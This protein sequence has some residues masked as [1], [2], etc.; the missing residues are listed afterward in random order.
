[1]I[2]KIKCNIC[3]N[4]FYIDKNQVKE[5]S[6]NKGLSSLT[7]G[8]NVYNAIDCPNCGCQKIL[9]TRLPEVKK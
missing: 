4:R 3:N 6:E 8:S 9:W 5:V 2:K 7:T 1:M